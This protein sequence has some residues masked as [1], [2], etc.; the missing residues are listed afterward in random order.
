MYKRQIEAGGDVEDMGDDGFVLLPETE[1]VE[2]G[3]VEK[4]EAAEPFDELGAEGGDVVGYSIQ[5]DAVAAVSYTHLDVY[6]RQVVEVVEVDVGEAGGVGGDVA[7][8]GEVN[9]EEGA[10]GAGVGGG[11]ELVAGEE[12]GVGGEGAEDDVGG[13]EEGGDAGEFDG[14]AFVGAGELLGVG[15]GAAGDGDGLG[16]AAAEGLEGALADFAGAEE[17]EVGV[18][19]VA[20]DAGGEFGGDVYKRQT[21]RT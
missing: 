13:D 8:D 3:G 12:G 1:A 11:G 15:E 14:G 2:F 9:D 5:F 10:A 4:M 19:G 18:G 7:G 16:A 6:K 20:E 17:E 21:Y